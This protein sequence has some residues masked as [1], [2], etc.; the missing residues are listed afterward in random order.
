[1][2]VNHFLLLSYSLEKELLVGRFF[3]Y[4]TRSPCIAFLSSLVVLIWGNLLESGQLFSGEV[5]W[6]GE[7]IFRVEIFL[8]RDYP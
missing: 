8:G 7:A 3:N 5:L 4:S 2:K 6:W 1:M